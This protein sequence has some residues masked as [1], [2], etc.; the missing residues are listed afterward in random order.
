MVMIGDITILFQ[1][2][3]TFV[4]CS[5]RS[6]FPYDLASAEPT[7]E[8]VGSKPTVT[9]AYQ[10]L[11][12]LST[13]G[14]N[15]SI[16]GS[17]SDVSDAE[18]TTD[19]LEP[20]NCSDSKLDE[21]DKLRQIDEDVTGSAENMKESCLNKWAQPFVPAAPS[22]DTSYAP[23]CAK[24]DLRSEA[25]IHANLAHV[26]R[27]LSP[28]DAATVSA[29]LQVKLAKAGM[30]EQSPQ[31]Q[32]DPLVEHEYYPSDGF[33]PPP[34]LCSGPPQIECLR[35][36]LPPGLVSR[37]T[38]NV[39]D[40]ASKM[41]VTPEL[42]NNNLRS[43]LN[44]LSQFDPACIFLVRK[45]NRLGLNSVDFLK[46]YFSKFGAV[47]TVMVS[48]SIEKPTPGRRKPRVRPAGLAFIV[49]GK[50]DEVASILRFGSEHVVNGVSI[51][52]S[53]YEHHQQPEETESGAFE[54]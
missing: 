26:I 15:N 48:H 51:C 54:E 16:N 22:P 53:T 13:D 37:K 35:E 49:M 30:S 36:P 39:H 1:S 29:F 31:E 40:G 38:K 3:S 33:K 27:S 24:S 46:E 42:Q 7:A 50:A 19:S 47:D 4:R 41:Q 6:R 25:D 10:D 34:G 8:V 43:N 2:I 11:C 44:K 23:R 20:G 52:A 21:L 14:S 32:P 28:A 9:P 12:G 17:S 5:R 18:S 45:I